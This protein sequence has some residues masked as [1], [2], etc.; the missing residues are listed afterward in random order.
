MPR[1]T[2]RALAPADLAAVVRIERAAFPDPWSANAF[3]ETLAREAARGVVLEDD[4]G[5]CIGYGICVLAADEGEILNLAVDP[6]HRRQG[7]GRALALAMLD[8]LKTGGAGRV[9]LEVRRSNEAAIGLY[10]ALG[11]VP[12]GERRAYYSQPRE[13]ALTMVL[14]VI[15]STA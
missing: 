8:L 13:D 15:Q 4:G 9:Y 2:V 3:R 1:P 12:L 10:R 5:H 6:K 11:F 14:D 7:S